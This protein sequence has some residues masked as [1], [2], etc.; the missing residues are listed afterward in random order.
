VLI[1][2]G[3]EGDSVDTETWAQVKCV[4][5]GKFQR[6]TQEAAS[7]NVHSSLLW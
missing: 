3:G 5:E 2:S 4:C 1:I 6:R 7:G